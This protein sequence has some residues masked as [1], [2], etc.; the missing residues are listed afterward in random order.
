MKQVQMYTEAN[1]L[2]F[3]SEKTAIMIVS[4]NQHLRNQFKVTLNNKEKQHSPNVKVLG[5]LFFP[6]T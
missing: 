2:K 1:M 6:V 5:N 3:N 4:N